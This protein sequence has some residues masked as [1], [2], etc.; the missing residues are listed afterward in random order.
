MSLVKLAAVR[1]LNEEPPHYK[2][3][4]RFH[5]A[6]GAPLMLA[7]TGAALSNLA[8]YGLSRGTLKELERGMRA[9]TIKKRWTRLQRERLLQKKYLRNAALAGGL[10]LGGFLLATAGHKRHRQQQ[11][12]E[13]ER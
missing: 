11:D 3:P 6:I 12:N 1:E 8:G 10:G 7:G 4:Y 2:D 9:G 5:R 13:R